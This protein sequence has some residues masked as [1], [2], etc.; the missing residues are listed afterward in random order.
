[1]KDDTSSVV[2]ENTLIRYNSCTLWKEETNSSATESSA[3][4]REVKKD[5]DTVVSGMW[6]LVTAIP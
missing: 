1:M 2:G 3:R 6:M 5:G 4:W